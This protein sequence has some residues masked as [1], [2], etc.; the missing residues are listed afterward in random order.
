M[1]CLLPKRQRLK[2][3]LPYRNPYKFIIKQ[4]KMVVGHTLKELNTRFVSETLLT[5]R[6]LA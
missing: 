3:T 5:Q 1:Y 4:L 2:Q 6:K